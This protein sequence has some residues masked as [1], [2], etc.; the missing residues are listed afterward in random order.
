MC[1]ERMSALIKGSG[2]KVTQVSVLQSTPSPFVV[3]ER[4]ETR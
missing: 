3:F 1:G 2:D 4:G